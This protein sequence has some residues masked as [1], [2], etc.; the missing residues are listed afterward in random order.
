MHVLEDH[1]HRLAARQTFELMDQRLQR[2]LLLAL[3]AEVRRQGMAL[4]SWQ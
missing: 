2:P 1:D 4:G 3:W